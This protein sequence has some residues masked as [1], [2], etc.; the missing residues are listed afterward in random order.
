VPYAPHSLGRE[1][2]REERGR[3]GRAA[4]EVNKIV[5]GLRRGAPGGQA[6]QTYRAS[7]SPS[8]NWLRGD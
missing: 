1:P 3:Q 7:Q 8:S 2:S 4:G 5:E 6:P